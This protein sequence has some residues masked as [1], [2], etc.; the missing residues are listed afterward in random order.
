MGGEETI[1]GDF[2]YDQLAIEQGWQHGLRSDIA[3]ICDKFHLE[4]FKCCR[5]VW[6]AEQ[7]IVLPKAFEGL[8]CGLR[9]HLL[10]AFQAFWVANG[11]RIEEA[12]P[13]DLLTCIQVDGGG[14][15]RV[16]KNMQR[17]R[18]QVVRNLHKSLFDILSLVLRQP[19]NSIEPVHVGGR[20][21]ML[22]LGLGRLVRAAVLAE[23]P[24]R[25]SPLPEVK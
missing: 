2:S 4:L 18:G 17:S 3:R 12:C 16:Q 22:P 13:S 11:E 7:I 1:R 6:Y 10:H 23:S 21:G 25:T 20:A 15:A 5:V 14:S 19:G 8:S 24:V 9:S